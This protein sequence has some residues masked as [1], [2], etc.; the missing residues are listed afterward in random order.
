M[1]FEAPHSN[2]FFLFEMGVSVS[3]FGRTVC[4]NC[5]GFEI[6]GVVPPLPSE[7]WNNS[8]VHRAWLEAVFDIVRVIKVIE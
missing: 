6:V 5:A 8:H 3:S 2:F 4:V 1:I 7:S